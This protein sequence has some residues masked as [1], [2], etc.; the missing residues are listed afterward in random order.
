MAKSFFD[1][2]P[3]LK[4]EQEMKVLFEDTEVTKVAT[5]SD[6]TYLHIHLSSHH[7]IEKKWIYK[8]ERMIKEQLFGRNRIQ[9]EICE[10]Y[11]LSELYTFGNLL[12][13]YYD[14]M[15]LELRKASIV[16]CNLFQEAEWQ[17]LSEG[18][19]QLEVEDTIV[20]RGKID[21]LVDYLQSTFSKRFGMPIRI[22]V[23]YR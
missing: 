12:Q 20:A 2:F 21:F 19:I 18:K 5:N 13:E 8:L 23:A 16:V 11:E 1:V 7:L 15:L 14:S 6:R 9:V 4:I 17:V 3:T 22:E 10:R